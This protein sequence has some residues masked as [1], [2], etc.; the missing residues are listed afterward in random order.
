MKFR[1]DEQSSTFRIVFKREL[2]D[3]TYQKHKIDE[4][5]GQPLYN[6]YGKPVYETYQGKSKFP[7]TVITIFRDKDNA[8]P[9]EL[10]RTATVGCH[11]H[12]SYSPE[13]GRLN[14]LRAV[15]RTL[16]KA[17]KRQ[18][19]ESYLSDKAAQRAISKAAKK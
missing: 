16:D 18:L 6:T 17:F 15:S 8:V 19:W 4:N 13:Q 5:T 14:A 2:K 11:H 9:G 3:V 12:E 7:N 1:V 10:F